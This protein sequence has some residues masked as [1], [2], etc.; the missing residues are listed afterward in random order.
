MSTPRRRVVVEAP[1]SSPYALAQ[2][3]VGLEEVPGI[4][5]NPTILKMLQLDQKWPKDDAVPWCS[6][7]LNYVCW[8]LRLPRS[9]SLAARSWLGVGTPVKLS[10]ARAGYDVVVINR[11]G[12][13]DP[14]TPGPGHVGF[15]AGIEDQFVL[16]LGGNQGDKVSLARFPVSSVLGV[17]RLS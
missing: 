5:A 17:R 2:R 13:P 16:L 1:G 10:D 11:N 6:A 15:F 14:S 7:F 9:K 12:S 3:Y 8:Q 4:A